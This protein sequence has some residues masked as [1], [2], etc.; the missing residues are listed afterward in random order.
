MK[1][2][3]EYGNFKACD[4]LD[5]HNLHFSYKELAGAIIQINLWPKCKSNFLL[6]PNSAIKKITVL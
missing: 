3:I 5:I 4:N 1:C 6:I 2:D